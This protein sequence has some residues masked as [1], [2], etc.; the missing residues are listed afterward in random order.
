[1]RYRKIPESDFEITKVGYTVKAVYN[2]WGRG[3]RFSA[4]EH[5]NNVL[6]NSS[7][8]RQTLKTHTTKI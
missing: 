5:Q 1:M 4:D 6:P 3:T 8:G 2:I 7:T